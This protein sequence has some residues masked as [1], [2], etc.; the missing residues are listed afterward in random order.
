[1]DDDN[2][3]INKLS[4]TGAFPLSVNQDFILGWQLPPSL[5]ENIVQDFKN[6]KSH[7][8]IA[9]S[10]RG[11]TYMTREF[12]HPGATVAYESCLDVLVDE[13][14]RHFPYAKEGMNAFQ[15][16]TSYNIQ[17]YPPGHHYSV[18]HCENNGENRFQNRHL[19]FMTYLNTV[20]NGGETHFLHQD[21]KIKPKTGLTLIWPAY[22]THTHMGLPAKTEEKYVTTGWYTFFDTTKALEEQNSMDDGDFYEFLNS[23]DKVV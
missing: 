10:T 12:M 5:C 19:A 3:F 21:L 8:K 4:P 20:E 7:H 9:H 22:F 11:Y 1:M 16:D 14:S 2:Y 15:L 13:Y 17:F 23:L 6:K 18:M